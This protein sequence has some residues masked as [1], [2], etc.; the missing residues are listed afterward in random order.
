MLTT[1][2]LKH[3]DMLYMYFKV[4]LPPF[5]H[6]LPAPVV[7]L[8]ECPLREREVAGSNPG[9]DIPKSLKMVLAAPRLALR[10]TG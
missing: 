10:L 6:L 8:E 2:S 9:R 4:N 7:Q 1:V 3:R 5:T